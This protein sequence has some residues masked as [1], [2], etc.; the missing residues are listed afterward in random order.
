[1]YT[2]TYTY[3][4]HIYIYI[5]SHLVTFCNAR[6]RGITF[7]L[8]YQPEMLTILNESARHRKSTKCGLCTSAG[9]KHTFCLE[10][11]PAFFGHTLARAQRFFGSQGSIL[12]DFTFPRLCNR[13]AASQRL[14]LADGLPRAY[15]RRRSQG[16]T[17]V[18]FIM[19]RHHCIFFLLFQD[20]CF[21]L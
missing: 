17:P 5:Y 7:W 11:L 15:R 4:I 21:V 1:M 3:I 19:R 10:P 18:K 9:G 2:H 12:R 16:R 6:A 14:G 13:H 20:I 8:G